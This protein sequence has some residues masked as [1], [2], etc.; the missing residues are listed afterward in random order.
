MDGGLQLEFIGNI[1][2]LSR[3][4]VYAV[5]FRFQMIGLES[6]DSKLSRP[7]TFALSPDRRPL[8]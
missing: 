3:V 8:W 2:R 1:A 7:P 6:I 4:Q 5:L